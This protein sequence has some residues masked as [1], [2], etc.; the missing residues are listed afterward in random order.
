[1][2]GKYMINDMRR[3][4]PVT[5]PDRIPAPPV[6]G[7][8]AVP[9]EAAAPEVKYDVSQIR[10]QWKEYLLNR[11]M[12]AQSGKWLDTFKELLPKLT[13]V[14]GKEATLLVVG[15]DAVATYRRDAKLN[16]ARLAK[17]QPQII[18]AYTRIIAEEK[19]DEAAFARDMPEVHAMYRG[20]SL[21]LIA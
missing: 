1:M 20:R 6:Q 18:E 13:D 19:F 10:L 15:E 9:T 7:T 3:T 11:E 21:R 8:V 17:E 2:T 14:G 12:N 4:T 5:F 16:M